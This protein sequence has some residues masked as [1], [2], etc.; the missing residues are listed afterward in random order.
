VVKLRCLLVDDSEEFLAS[1]ERL[2][3]SQGLDVVGRAMS[4]ADA[5]VRVA[6]LAPDV[7]LVDIELA[8]EDGIALASALDEQTPATRVVLISAH[9]QAD[10]EGLL[11]DCPAV[12]FLPKR[13]LGAE[14]IATL[15]GG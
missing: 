5:L 14:A 11:R 8:E 3:E 1:A 7:A 2:L 6:D 12:G 4:S 15:L 10:V 13:R 9:E